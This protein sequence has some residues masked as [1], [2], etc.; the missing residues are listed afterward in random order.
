MGRKE[1]V[2]EGDASPAAATCCY[3]SGQAACLAEG[4]KTR[5]ED[6]LPGCYAFVD[7]VMQRLARRG[8]QCR[9]S[10]L[11]ASG[12]SKLLTPRV[13]HFNRRFSSATYNR[14]SAPGAQAIVMQ[15]HHLPQLLSVA[16]M[17]A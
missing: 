12:S 7:E 17:Y 8:C 6:P 13:L 11:V 16:P 4:V 9:L 3:G 1:T 2:N 15:D 14:V 5:C 10:C